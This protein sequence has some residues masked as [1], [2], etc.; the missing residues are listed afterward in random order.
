M[1]ALYNREVL[2]CEE[3]SM[4]QIRRNRYIIKTGLRFEVRNDYFCDHCGFK[5][6]M[7][8]GFCPMCGLTV[9]PAD[10]SKNTWTR[11]K[12]YMDDTTPKGSRNRE[13]LGY[14]EDEDDGLEQN[15][16]KLERIDDFDKYLE[17]FNEYME[18]FYRDTWEE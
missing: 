17:E 3:L 18:D 10:K 16:E 8:K 2:P 7:S 14:S 12:E 13:V 1:Q 9:D 11:T 5:Y 4:R 6:P 15:G